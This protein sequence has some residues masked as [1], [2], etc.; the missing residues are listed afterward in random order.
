MTQDL[1][2]ISHPPHRNDRGGPEMSYWGTRP[3]AIE[4]I[5]NKTHSLVSTTMDSLLME[6]TSGFFGGTTLPAPGNNGEISEE[7]SIV[8]SRSPCFSISH[9][10][11]RKKV[12]KSLSNP[13]PAYTKI[14][15]RYD[16]TASQPY[17]DL[18]RFT[19]QPQNIFPNAWPTNLVRL[20]GTLTKR[21][22][23]T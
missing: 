8:S 10:L 16:R 2:L 6:G 12:K 13:S 19:I 20:Y 9:P 22:K 1:S 21:M 17:P 15:I 5:E 7:R 11:P 4:S 23:R 18:R 3:E 14:T